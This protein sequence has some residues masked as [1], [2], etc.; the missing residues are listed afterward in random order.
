MNTKDEDDEY[1]RF[2]SYVQKTTLDHLDGIPKSKEEQWYGT[3]RTCLKCIPIEVG[4]KLIGLSLFGFAVYGTYDQVAW[5]LTLYEMKYKSIITFFLTHGLLTLFLW[6]PTILYLRFFCSKT[7]ETA[8]TRESLVPAIGYL[9]IWVVLHYMLVLLYKDSW[10]EALE[11]FNIELKQDAQHEA[12]TGSPHLDSLKRQYNLQW[13]FISVFQLGF[14]FYC[15]MVTKRFV[16]FGT[17]DEES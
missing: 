16:S 10:L 14:S 5:S 2:G 8:K 11:A 17:K 9:V 6:S 4:I 13:I 12:A 7:T 3:D 1:Q 15:Y